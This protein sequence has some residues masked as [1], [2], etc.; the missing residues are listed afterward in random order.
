MPH[1][2]CKLFRIHSSANVRI[3][4]GKIQ[5][6]TFLDSIMKDLQ[7]FGDC[8]E[9]SRKKLRMQCPSLLFRLLLLFAAADSNV[10]QQALTP[11]S[12]NCWL[13]TRE[14]SP[15]ACC[16]PQKSTASISYHLQLPKP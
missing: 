13:K 15:E 6:N 1:P 12:L 10:Q 16:L 8:L 9:N 7:T 11:F 4:D 14:T 3:L 5:E 2:L